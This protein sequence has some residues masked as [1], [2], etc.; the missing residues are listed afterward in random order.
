MVYILASRFVANSSQFG[1]KYDS[2]QESGI[3][4]TRKEQIRFGYLGSRY[5]N[6]NLDTSKRQV[7]QKPS[8][9]DGGIAG[10]RLYTLLS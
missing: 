6:E 5:K 1:N 8:P 2:D 9:R 4:L 10:S 3:I 7:Q